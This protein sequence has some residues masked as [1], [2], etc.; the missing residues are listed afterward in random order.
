MIKRVAKCQ[1]RPPIKI[2]I[3]FQHRIR[4]ICSV[5]FRNVIALGIYGSKSIKKAHALQQRIAGKISAAHNQKWRRR[6]L[7]F[8]HNQSKLPFYSQRFSPLVQHKTS[9]SIFFSGEKAT[10]NSGTNLE[11]SV[12][13]LNAFLHGQFAR[14]IYALHRAKN[15]YTH[16]VSVFKNVFTLLHT[17]QLCCCNSTPSLISELYSYKS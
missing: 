17:T 7:P 12:P 6:G 11:N 2:S 10:V 4:N 15:T 8:M 16:S 13:Q 3:Y 5:Y 1:Y 14:S 9:N